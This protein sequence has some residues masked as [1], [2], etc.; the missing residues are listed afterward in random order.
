[1]TASNVTTRYFTSYSGV[2]LPLKLV[3]ELASED[4]RNRNTFYRGGFDADGRL[5]RCEKVVY[6][7]IEVCHEYRY[8][9]DGRLAQALIHDANGEEE[10]LDYP[11]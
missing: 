7:E 1:M 3:G 11:A 5:V 2:R 8:H 9:A 10:C 4:M 6:G